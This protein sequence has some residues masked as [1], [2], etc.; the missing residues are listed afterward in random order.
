MSEPDTGYVDG[1]YIILSHESN[2]N[3]V[4]DKEYTPLEFRLDQNYP[5]P[6]NPSTAI[7]YHL[8]IP[9]KVIL[10]VFDINGRLVENLVDS[11]QQAGKYSVIFEKANLSS[12]IYIYQLSLNGLIEQNKMILIH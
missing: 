10:N 3:T 5:N 1:D 4:G 2:V 6:F 8:N 12:G 9:G 7:D 11:F